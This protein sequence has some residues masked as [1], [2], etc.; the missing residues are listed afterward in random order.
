[1]TNNNKNQN[2]YQ[3]L[4]GKLDEFIRKFYKN[5]M[6]RGGI[7]IFSILLLSFLIVTTLEYF[8][9]FSTFVRTFL[10]YSFILLNSVFIIQFLLIPLFKLRKIGKRISHNQASEI[11][12]KHF[13][14]VRD[15]LVN[16]LQLKELEIAN[17]QSKNIIEAS[18]NQRINELKPLKF[19]NAVDFKENK[20]YLKFSVIPLIIVLGITFL[21]P[22]IFKDSTERIVEHNKQ[23]EKP[24]PFKFLVLNQN[25]NAIKNENFII[26]IKVKGDYLPDKVNIKLGNVDYQMR[27]VQKD[28][29]EYEIKNIRNEIDFYLFSGKYNSNSFHI[30]VLPK[31]LLKNFSVQLDYP[32]YIGKA[33]EELE[34]VGDL[35]IP[36]GTK[37]NWMFNTDETDEIK[38]VFQDTNYIAQRN[39]QNKFNFSKLFRDNNYYS[40]NTSNEFLKSNDSILY[41]VTI[42]P[43]AYPQINVEEQIDSFSTKYKFFTGEASDDYGISSLKFIYR[44]TKSSDSSKLNK[45]FSDN[46]SINIG[47]NFQQ[48]YYSYNFKNIDIQPGEEIEYYFKV[49][50]N[51]QVNGNKSSTS[52]KFYFKAPSKKEIEDMT[53]ELSEDLKEE[54]EKAA[55]KAKDLQKDLQEARKKM[56][57]NKELKWEDEKFIEDI[58]ERQKTLDEDIEKLKEKLAEK[59]TKEDEFKQLDEEVLDK[60]EQLYEMMDQLMPEEMKEMYEE[61]E[62]MLQEKLKNQIQNELENMDQQNLDVE[63]E[64][65]R[66]LEMYKRFEVE[67]KME[68]I[69]E[70][71]EEMAEKQDKLAEKTGDKKQDKEAL[72]EEQEQLNKEFEELQE[73]IDKVGELNKELEKPMEMEDTESDES[74]IQEEQQNSLENM[75]EGKNNKAQQNQKNAAQKMK[76]MAEK[77]KEMQAS[78]QME[79]MSI[80]I[81]KLKQI[82]ENLLYL[83]F[84]QESLINDLK[85]VTSYSPKYIELAQKQNKLIQEA[86]M[87]EDSLFALSKEVPTISSY[88]NK[89][90][91]DMRQNLEKANQ[92]MSDRLIEQAR[93]KQQYVMTSANNIAVLLSEILKQMQQESMSMSGKGQGDQ[94]KKGKG[95][96]S[97]S[98]LKKMQEQ[99]KQQLQD[100]KDGKIPSQQMSQQFAQMVAQQEMIREALRKLDQQ[101]NKGGDKPY[102]D[103]DEIQKLMEETE[104]DLI[105]KRITEETLKRQKEISI[106]LLEAEKA[107]K[108][109]EKDNKRE[110]RTARDIFRKEIPTLEEYQ[111]L[112]EKEVELYRTVPP[113]LTP[114]YKLKVKEYF[115]LLSE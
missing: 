13:Q 80:N 102:G 82:L 55:E 76:K 42:I 35:T 62:M 113:N 10:F 109:Q 29:F 61:L 81:E 24:A 49:W 93:V 45:S 95:E 107:E 60:Y 39:S 94:K 68:E 4:I 53:D 101:K 106:K 69:T 19:T 66:M 90:I 100:M 44:F 58:L 16:T 8:G 1:M 18:I 25:L 92:F 96:Q 43:D 88:I 65:D 103:L 3:L 71:L 54:M 59:A 51:D 14:N 9:H 84:E 111:K 115:R 72:K 41:Y 110:S 36:E 83:S 34:N 64:L 17:P 27:R 98:D 79:A 86:R 108:Q 47:Q 30:N 15:K 40:I 56:L 37:V 5:Q 67:Q 70:D 48:F 20:K 99:L 78:M 52:K 28:E 2:N 11:I 38:L 12:G 75:E 33:N 57:E 21:Q 87:I 7:L 73:K 114:Y 50:D 46:I 23:F 63:K 32:S 85:T 22:S 105:N 31:P 104:K 6:L 26:K 74:E 89:D 112:K 97:I 91:S 77:M